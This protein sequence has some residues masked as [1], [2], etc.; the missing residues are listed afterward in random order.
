MIRGSKYAKGRK[1]LADALAQNKFFAGGVSCLSLPLLIVTHNPFRR[2]ARY[3][4]EAC[5]SEFEN[6]NAFCSHFL[7]NGGESK[8]KQCAQARQAELV[9]IR[10]TYRQVASI[11]EGFDNRIPPITTSEQ[12]FQRGCTRPAYFLVWCN[13]HGPEPIRHQ[14]CLSHLACGFCGAFTHLATLDED[15]LCFYGECKPGFL[16]RFCA[17][18]GFAS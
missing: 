15:A 7:G 18:E 16:C 1:N 2:A 5:H 11:I 14:A 6:V 9:R 13:R 12:C 8:D 10:H 3:Q 4:C 17:I